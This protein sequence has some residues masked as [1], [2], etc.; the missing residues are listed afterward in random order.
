MKQH[1]DVHKEIKNALLN[2]QAHVL[3]YMPLLCR[4]VHL[5]RLP[6]ELDDREDAN[7]CGM[8]NLQNSSLVRPNRCRYHQTIRHI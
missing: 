5:K 1:K 4:A 6:N 7:H 2:E 8:C 3:I